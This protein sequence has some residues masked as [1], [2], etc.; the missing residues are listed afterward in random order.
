[1]S[2]ARIAVGLRYLDG[3]APGRQSRLVRRTQYHHVHFVASDD[4]HVYLRPHYPENVSEGPS[5]RRQARSGRPSGEELQDPPRS[6]DLRRIDVVHLSRR[7]TSKRSCTIWSSSALERSRTRTG[8]M[9]RRGTNAG[10]LS[11][12]V[13]CNCQ[14]FS[15]RVCYPLVLVLSW[16]TRSLDV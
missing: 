14:R 2:R 1:M 11:R 16:C 13:A 15:C 7:M 10:E 8:D 3:V 6:G 9:A 12:C 5:R 4:V